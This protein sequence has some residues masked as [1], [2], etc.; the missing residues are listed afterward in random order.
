MG[1]VVGKQEHPLE[2]WDAVSGDVHAVA[3]AGK[4]VIVG[5]AE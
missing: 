3:H 1:V 4:E 2:I 5:V